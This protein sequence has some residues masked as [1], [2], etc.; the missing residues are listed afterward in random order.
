MSGLGGAID[1]ASP[2]SVIRCL[3]LRPMG[4]LPSLFS[5]LQVSWDQDTI[6]SV[7]SKFELAR[8]GLT[9]SAP[10]EILALVSID[11]PWF[12]HREDEQ[13]RPCTRLVCIL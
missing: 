5:D 6:C 12:S 1:S 7:A 11:S 2:R 4:S 3:F 13:E 10:L 8:G 9:S